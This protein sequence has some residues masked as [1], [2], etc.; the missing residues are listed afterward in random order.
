MNLD[1]NLPKNVLVGLEYFYNGQGNRKPTDYQ[2]SRFLHGDIQQM[3]KNYGAFLV[4]HE[5]T[6]LWTVANR[7]IMNMDDSSYFVRPEI[8]YEATNNFILGAAVQLYL[9]D[10]TEEFGR[11]Q[12]LYLMEATYSF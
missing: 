4:R 2:L 1:Y 11:G 12:N 10:N 9:G 6:A 3:A 5:L 7:F 8:T